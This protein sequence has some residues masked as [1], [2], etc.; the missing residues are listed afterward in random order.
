M[1]HSPL[2]VRI[3]S[4]DGSAPVGVRGHSDF[5]VLV[6]REG[7]IDVTHLDLVGCY[8]PGQSSAEGFWV[9]LTPTS[10]ILGE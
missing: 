5:E 6:D 4:A 1:I 10:V 8:E 9:H 7:A 3:G 2:S